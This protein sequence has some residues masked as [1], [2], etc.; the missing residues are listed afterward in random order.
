[1][2]VFDCKKIYVRVMRGLTKCKINKQ[3]SGK[4]FIDFKF[5]SF[6]KAVSKQ[7]L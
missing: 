1:M 2:E 4:I 5:R 7:I 3:R 6:L